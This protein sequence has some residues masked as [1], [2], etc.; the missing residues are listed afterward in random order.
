MVLCERDHYSRDVPADGPNRI[1]IESHRGSPYPPERAFVVQFGATQSEPGVVSRV[2][3]V[4]SGRHAHFTDVTSLFAFFA[5]VLASEGGAA[6]I[7]GTNDGPRDD[8]NRSAHDLRL[9]TETIPH[10]LWSA[11]PEGRIDYVNQRV[12]DYAQLPYED[13]LGAGWGKAIHPDH[14]ARMAEAWAASIATGEPFQFEFLGRH[15]PSQSWRW[16]VS[17][18]VPARDADGRILKWYGSV[19]DLHDRKQAEETRL[20]TEREYRAVV[21]TATDAVI[22]I[23]ESSRI[24]LV[25]PAVTTIFGYDASELVGQPLTVLMPESLASRHLA[26]VQRYLET[27]TPHVNW[28]ALELTGRRKNGEEFPVEISFA[29]VV[30]E[31][32]RRFTGFIRDISERKQ[33]EELRA[34]R[35]RQVAIRAD[36][37]SALAAEGSLRTILQSCAEAVVK[38]LDAAFARIWVLTKDARFL[39]LQASAGLYTNLDGAH[40]LIPFGHLKI[41][42]IAEQRMPHVTNDILNDPRLSD[43][44]WA[45][46]E[47][48]VAFAGYPLVVNGAVVGVLAMFSRVP[49]SAATAETLAS[50]SDAIAQGIRRK[51]AE[52]QVRRS[53]M[54]LAEAQAL[55]Q[56]GSWG[57]NS[58]TGDLFWSRETYRML[59]LPPDVTPT[60][61]RVV[62]AIHPEDRARFERDTASLARDHT[63]FEREYRLR[64]ADGSIKHVHVVGRFVTGVFPDLDFVGSIMDVS[65][66][67]RAAD[68]LLRAQ[69]EL[70]DVTRLTTMGEL[71][72][73]IAHEI[74][75][76]LATVVT[77]AQACT[78]L[79]RA[80]P[81]PWDDI[82]SAVADIAEAGKRASDVIARIRLLLRKG[83]P[84]PSALS[85]ND[86]VREV[87]TLTH[88]ALRQQQV[89]PIVELAGDLPPVLADRVQLQ[90][91]LI[92]LITN[93]ADAMAGVVDR[94]RTLTIRSRLDETG[95]VEIAVIDAGCGIDPAHQARMFDAFFT[96]KADGMGMGLAICRGIVDAHG[97]RL[98]ATA[99]A[100][101]GTTVRFSLPVL[102]AA[103]SP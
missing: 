31:G 46:A 87:M 65:E 21:E 28:A 37:S 99:N 91:V 74:N 72:A 58:T 78:R 38:H 55:S 54:F 19:V 11:T 69:S 80:S 66:R 49:I 40:R 94:A 24:C 27:G 20:E 101:V 17:S 29:A 93:A 44:A 9:L 76:P 16:C 22:T 3:H 102:A 71:A 26:G 81:P 15:A 68:A 43:P 2:E 33:A 88:D 35:G 82:V 84:E 1:D 45:R 70:A 79:L 51:H 103:G 39:E 57:W 52:E 5:D 6:E 23:D 89:V 73:S 90:Q 53:E 12:I 47:R 48:M 63:D 42:R 50:I 85:L 77:N 8:A 14:A 97:G 10:M 56:T 36:V 92:N 60:M 30:T 86:I 75:Q 7:P 100:D 4:T 98:S 67:K 95:Q 62:E 96:T 18:A 32:H 59:D 13:F 61:S 25:N 34:A 83:V 64:L 41:G